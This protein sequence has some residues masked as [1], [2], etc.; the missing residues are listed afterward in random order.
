[1]STDQSPLEKKGN[2]A[3]T[4]EAKAQPWRKLFPA[5]KPD[6]DSSGDESGE[7]RPWKSWKP[8]PDSPDEKPWYQWLNDE[9]FNADGGK[10]TLTLSKEERGRGEQIPTRKR[11][12]SS[13]TAAEGG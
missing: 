7:E 4:E 3:S 11:S 10:K 1:M 5:G 13:G 6:S 12:A 2:L 9:K 8:D